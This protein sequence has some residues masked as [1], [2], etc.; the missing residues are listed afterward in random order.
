MGVRILAGWLTSTLLTLGPGLFGQAPGAPGQAVHSDDRPESVF[1]AAY[2]KEALQDGGR[3]LGAPARWDGQDWTRAN[4]ALAGI[5]GTGILL[6]RPVRDLAARNRTPGRDRLSDHLGYLGTYGAAAFVGGLYLAGAATANR[7]AQLA[8][9]DA[10]TASL[11]ASGV[12]TPATK[13][14]LGRAR[15]EASRDPGSFRPFHQG[16]PGFPSNH[17]VEAFAVASV[18]S[19]R[20]DSPWV[21]GVAYGLAGM[22]GLSRLQLNQHYASDVVA[23]AI[24]GTVVGRAVVFAHASGPGRTVALEPGLVPGGV[25]LTVMARF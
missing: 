10:L 21:G 3:I 17:T 24:L 2:G 7:E 22:V 25:G 9:M 1:S 18:V 6:D 16:D 14:I 19:A 13:V 15:P 11:I 12:I 4:W 8:A 23:G 20:S 5:V